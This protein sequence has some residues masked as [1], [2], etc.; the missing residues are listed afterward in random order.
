MTEIRISRKELS[1]KG[2]HNI[3]IGK[4][5][6]SYCEQCKCQRVHYCNGKKWE[7]GQLI[8]RFYC[9]KCKERLDGI[10]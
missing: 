4:Q 1:D 2:W 5:I 9:S 10:S 8:L 3:D 6:I 7:K